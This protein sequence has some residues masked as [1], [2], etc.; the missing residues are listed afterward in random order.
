MKVTRFGHTSVNV[1][2]ALEETLKFYTEFLGLDE[3]PRPAGI[4]IPGAWFG[5]GDAQIHLIGAE[6]NGEPGNPIGPHY[7]V[8]V[9]DLEAAVVEIEAAGLRYLRL[10]KGLA[11]QVWI[12]DPAGNTIE[13]QQDPDVDV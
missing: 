4:G 1:H 12:T 10:G 2:G 3:I 5:A 6:D 11:S 9:A 7:A 8:L 13:F